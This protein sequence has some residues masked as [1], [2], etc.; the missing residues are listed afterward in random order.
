MSVLPS[1]IVAYGSLNMPETDSVAIGGAVDFTKR[2]AFYDITPAGTVDVVPSSSS[3]TAT[4]MQVQGRDS[5]GVIQT[6]TAVTLTGITPVIGSQS[7]ERMLCA[8]LSGGNT[9]PGST[10]L[11]ANPGGTPAVG[12][13]AV[14]AHTPV[15]LAHT[16]QTGS[17]NHNGTTPA[18]FKLQAGDGAAV[19]LGQIIRITSATGANQLRQIIALTGYGT[20]IVGVSR[21]WTTVPDDTSVYNILQGML[22]E[23]LPNPVT[24][25]ARCFSTSAADIPNGSTRF[26]YEKVFVTNNNTATALTGAQIEIASET[27]TLPTGALLDIAL[28]T[29]LN[30]TNTTANRQTA[31]AAGAGSFMTQPTFVSVPGA[32][33]LPS[34]SAPN[35]SGSQGV[36]LRLTLPAGAAAYKGAA[37]LR[38]QGTTT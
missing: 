6:P 37:D 18:L 11:L 33:I 32:G 26:Y 15:I 38:A 23:V 16:A 17:S 4:L 27:P 3:D 1:D 29:A 7:F 10:F 34:G 22:F 14:Y 12:D 20:D 30:D 19:S 35:A 5:S 25:I 2:I 21:D 8:I 13:V 9:A 31:P 24:A 28:C 36:W